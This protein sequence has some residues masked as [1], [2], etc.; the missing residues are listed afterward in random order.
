MTQQTATAPTVI[1]EAPFHPSL[2][3]TDLARAKAW[4]AD[5][6]GW[7]PMIEPPE[8][9]VYQVGD[10]FFTLY[11]SEFA[12]TAKN[13]VMNWIVPDVRAE[14]PRLRD[15]G[16]TFEDYD[17]GEIR[18]ED[19][20]MADP[21]GGLTAWFKDP[22]SNTIGLISAGPD[23]PAGIPDSGVSGM[24]AA[25]DLGR[26]RAWYE[27]K[28]GFEPVFEMED[29]VVNYRSGDSTFTVYQTEFAGTAKN[30]VGIWR[31]K[32]IRDEVARLRAAGIEFEEYDFGPEGRT[33]DGILTDDEGDA[34]A[35]FKDS[36]GNILALAEDRGGLGG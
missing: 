33:V 28:L 6:L 26:A 14:V 13:T 8:T 17:F 15:R 10:S 32:G 25:S 2:A 36:E 7:E 11:T 29:V 16:V 1:T 22:D 12:G 18:T 20:I 4:Y 21:S 34:N 24:I 35:W 3:V 27:G 5:K 23:A 19:G 9:L 30:T 31:L